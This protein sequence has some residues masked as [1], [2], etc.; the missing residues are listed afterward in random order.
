MAARTVGFAISDEDRARLD[1]LV[2][3]HGGGN[4]SEF[5]RVAIRVLTADRRAQR[6]RE[7]QADIHRDIGRV[8][9]PDEVNAMVKRVLRSGE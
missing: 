8:V 7:L 1:D 4:R 3:Y 2:E 5:L 9:S 6:L